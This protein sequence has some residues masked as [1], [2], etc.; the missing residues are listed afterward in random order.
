M[1]LAKEN[2]NKAF[3]LHSQGDYKNAEKFY[4][5]V[6]K[7][8]PHNSEALNLLG[9]LKYQTNNISDAEKFIK[10]AIKYEKNIYY[11]ENLA[12]IYI[13]QEEWEKLI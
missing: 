6:L 4:I 13:K 12:G 1:D 8:N 11:Y 5:K 3:S 9:L 2:L 7:E 10:Q